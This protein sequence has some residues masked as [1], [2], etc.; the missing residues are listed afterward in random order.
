MLTT[1]KNVLEERTQDL[2]DM[3]HVLGTIRHM[4]RRSEISVRSLPAD[5]RTRANFIE[6]VRKK[7]EEVRKPDVEVSE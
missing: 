1:M 5:Q 7:R 2:E 4:E 6:A 3:L